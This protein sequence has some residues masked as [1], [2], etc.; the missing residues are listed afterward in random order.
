[1]AGMKKMGDVAVVL[2][3]DERFDTVANSYK[4]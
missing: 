2:L 4:F 3:V 1:M